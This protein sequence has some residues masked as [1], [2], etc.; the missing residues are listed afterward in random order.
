[1]LVR[2][3]GALAGVAVDAFGER[4]EAPLRPMTG[5]LAGAAGIAGATMVGDGRVLVVLDLPELIG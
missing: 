1:V 2:A 5:L 4:L 3:G